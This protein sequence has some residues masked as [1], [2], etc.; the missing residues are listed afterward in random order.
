MTAVGDFEIEVQ[1]ARCG[2]SLFYEPCEFCP[3]C[4]W[5]GSFDPTC[6]RCHG[7]G[8]VPWCC[9]SDEWCQ[10]NPL[11]G[12]EDT[13]RHTPEEFTIA[14]FRDSDAGGMS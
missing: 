3:A 2:S 12:R 14:G 13:P 7:T 11:P 9:S 10:A 4:G 1:C 6:P 8:S 5:Y